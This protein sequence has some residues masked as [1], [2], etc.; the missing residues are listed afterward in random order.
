MRRPRAPIAHRL[1]AAADRLAVGLRETPQRFFALASAAR[2]D[3]AVRKRLVHHLLQTALT[4][5]AA[6]TNYPSDVRDLLQLVAAASDIRPFRAEVL[7][8]TPFQRRRHNRHSH[9]MVSRHRHLLMLRALLWDAEADRHKA[10]ILALAWAVAYAVSDYDT[11]RFVFIGAGP[12][13]RLRRLAVFV[14][15]DP[16]YDP[17]A[18]AR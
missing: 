2:R 15:L 7:A 11:D 14:A 9:S 10:C 1:V 13:R 3:D 17:P 16:G 4:D 6:E 18:S 8:L 5:A 12:E